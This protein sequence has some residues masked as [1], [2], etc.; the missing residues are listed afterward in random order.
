M[1]ALTLQGL[2]GEP[3]RW[4]GSIDLLYNGVRLTRSSDAMQNRNIDACVE[5]ICNKG[6]QAVRREIELL[7]QGQPLP[8][9]SHLSL[10]ARQS[11]LDEL[12]AIMS[13]YGDSCR[14]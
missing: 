7:E 8:E 11:V 6:C 2:S 4:R 9:L 13:V 14:V 10:K 5:A 3:G 12:K 1:P